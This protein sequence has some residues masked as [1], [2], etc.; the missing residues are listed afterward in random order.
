MTIVS[1]ACTI[2]VSLVF[3]LALASVVNYDAP[4]CGVTY[5]RH[6]DNR[7]SFIIQATEGKIYP[8]TLQCTLNLVKCIS[9]FVFKNLIFSGNTYS[10]VVSAETDS[11]LS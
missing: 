2:N 7:N 6:Y 5:D 8:S 1:D 3:A 10:Y 9:I 4:N 11:A